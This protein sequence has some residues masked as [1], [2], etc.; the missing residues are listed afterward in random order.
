M[1]NHRLHSL[2]GIL[3]ANTFN[4]FASFIITIIVARVFSPEEFG[5]FALATA[6]TTNLSSILDF[7][8]NVAIVRLYN[9]ENDQT[10]KIALFKVIH[11]WNIGLLIFISIVFYPMGLFF[12]HIFSIFKEAALLV[13]LAIISAGL[14]NV[15]S[16][17]RAIEQ[18]KKNFKSFQSYTFTYAFLRLFTLGFFVITR[19]INLTS[20]YL[21]LYI[22]PLATL[23][24][25]ITIVKYLNRPRNINNNHVNEWRILRSILSYGFWIGL[26]N[27]LF[28]ILFQIPQFILART[29][30]ADE[31]GF[32]GAGYTFL[33]IFLLTNDAIR[34]I[35]LPD[36]S[37]IKDIKARQEFRKRLWKLCPIFF[38]IMFIILLAISFIQYFILG[39]SYHSSVPVFLAL[40]GST[41]IVMFLGYS[42]TLI[43]SLAIPHLVAMINFGRVVMFMLVTLLI[44]KN[45][46]YMSLSLATVLIV[47][48]VATYFII[49]KIDQQNPTI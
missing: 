7:G 27:I 45:A 46:L 38:T 47:G 15:W 22:L 26:G 32:Y 43:H 41:I 10:Y 44:P 18:S 39:K 9:V 5:Q 25:F 24:I 33:P 11:K 20:I 35:I 21:S 36:I 14:L 19:S 17:T 28:T 2:F 49:D 4:N 42:N 37:A 48:E 6:I 30:S 23:I 12:I 34:T 29:A 13:Y 40:G 3:G 16:T 1:K 8:T 31:V